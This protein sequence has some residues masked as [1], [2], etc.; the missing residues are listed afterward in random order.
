M[1]ASTGPQNVEAVLLSSFP[2]LREHLLHVGARG[3]GY[4]RNVPAHQLRPTI[5]QQP[6]YAIAHIYNVPWG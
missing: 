2:I 3:C 6:A 4:V 5:A 1:S